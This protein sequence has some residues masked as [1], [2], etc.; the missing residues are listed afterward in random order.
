MNN[1]KT[2]QM[3]I[4]SFR[5]E[6]SQYLKNNIGLITSVY[7]AKTGGAIIEI[8]LSVGGKNKDKYKGTSQNLGNALKNVKQ[9]TFGGNLNGFSFVGT[10]IILEP[11]KIILIK[12][13]SPNEWSS[14]SA[15]NDID[16]IIFNGG[17]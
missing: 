5:S 10:N 2:V 15:K 17:M 8:E 3:Y 16:K 4:N 11:S 12:S 13:D 1:K 9:S 14:T 6:F 7:F